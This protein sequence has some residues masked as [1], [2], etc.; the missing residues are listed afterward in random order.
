MTNRES[1]TFLIVDDDEVAVMAIKRALK[2]LRLVNPI[3]VV[4]DGQEALDLLRGVNSTALE[5]P[6]IILLDLNMPRMGGL[7]FLAEVREDKELAN[8]VIFVLTTS[9]APSDIAVA[10]EHKIAGYIVKENA[11]DAVK[12]AVEMLGAYVEIV[13]LENKQK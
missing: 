4:G 5:R 8:S 7:E 13:S 2:K 10:Y 6:Y 1:V 12:S 3:E 9:D 11:Y